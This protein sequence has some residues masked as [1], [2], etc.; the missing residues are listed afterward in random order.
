MRFKEY[1]DQLKIAGEDT[2]DDSIEIPQKK[3]HRCAVGVIY[4]R[5]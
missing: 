5:L 2:S 3:L 1:E 4:R